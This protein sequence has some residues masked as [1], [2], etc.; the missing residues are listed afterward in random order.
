MKINLFLILI[1]LIFSLTSIYS[2]DKTLLGTY[3]YD[4]ADTF[5]TNVYEISKESIV[6]FCA[7]YDL[8][9]DGSPRAYNP[10]NTGILHNDNGRNPYTKR[11]FAVVVK[12][13]VPILQDNYCP[14]PGFYISTTSLEIKKYK[15]NDYRRYIN[16]ESI[17]YF[18]LPGGKYKEY[19]KMNMKLGDIGLIYNLSNQRYVFAVFAD[20]GPGKIIGEGSIKLANEL[21]IKTYI[22]KKGRIRGGEDR[23]KIVY[24]LFP[25]S[26][27]DKYDYMDSTLINKIGNNLFKN[28]GNIH[29]YV[30]ALL[31]HK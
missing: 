2:Q 4:S 30:E 24:I 9:A 27:F 22:D 19:H 15:F 11:W 7:D 10:S 18:V 28:K 23:G 21:G 3:L 26:G 31:N 20:V 17:P 29:L 12:N 5:R 25:N 13:G 16:S 1:N 14:Y 6:F 8:D